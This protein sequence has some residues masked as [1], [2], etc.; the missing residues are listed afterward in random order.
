MAFAMKFP[1]N[2]FVSNIRSQPFVIWEL[3]HA[4]IF[5]FDLHLQM[6][7]EQLKVVN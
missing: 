5:G 1:R 6:E 2:F 7:F 4:A 3:V